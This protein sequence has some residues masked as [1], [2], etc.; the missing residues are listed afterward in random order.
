M[1]GISPLKNSSD[2]EKPLPSTSLGQKKSK[3]SEKIEQVRRR[4]E[5]AEQ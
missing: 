1:T 2:E 5:E 3:T 4:R